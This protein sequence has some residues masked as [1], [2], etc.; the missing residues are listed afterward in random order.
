MKRDF[1]LIRKASGEKVE[2]DP[3]KLR[4]SLHRTGANKVLIEEIIQI[5]VTELVPNQHTRSIYK[6]AFSLLRKK[7]RSYAARYKLK[8]AIMELGPSGFP[9]EKYLGE[10]FRLL[11]YKVQTGVIYQGFAVTHELDIVARQTGQLLLMECKFRNSPG[12]TCDVKVPLYIHSRFNDVVKRLNVRD[13]KVAE[14]RILTNTRFTL[15]A[16]KYANAYG[17]TL[18]SWDYPHKHSLRDLIDQTG[19]HPI[20]SLTSLTKKH[21]QELLNKGVV[22]CREICLEDAPALKSLGLKKNKLAQIQEEARG[23]CQHDFH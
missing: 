20:T 19:L 4:K 22:L 23:L 2:F 12:F 14:C 5:I 3:Q 6:R 13:Q 8:Q 17:I 11:G 1:H 7:R 18:M 21:K 16:V 15:D 10:L 9:F